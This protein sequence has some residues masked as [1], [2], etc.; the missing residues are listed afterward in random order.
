MEMINFNILTFSEYCHALVRN[1]TTV[2]LQVTYQYTWYMVR[3]I[4][5]RSGMV[6]HLL[7]AWYGGTLWWGIMLRARYGGA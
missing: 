4:V 3:H 5:C 1:H 6:G 2:L 7:C